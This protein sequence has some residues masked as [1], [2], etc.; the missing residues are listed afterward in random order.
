MDPFI[1]RLEER[2]KLPLPG[3]AAHN[4][5]RAV[6]VGPIRPDFS[7]TQPP[8]PGAV[9]ICLYEKDGEIVFPL[10]K[11]TEY[12][13]A[14]SGQISLPGGKAEPNEEAIGTAL[15]EAEEEI[16]VDPGQIR[17]IGTLTD[18][19]VIP[20]NFLVTPVV[21]AS[22]YTPGFRPDPREVTRILTA[23]L[24]E[25]TR[26]DAIRNKEILAG[27]KFPMMAPHFEVEGEIVWG[28]TAM[29]LNELCHVAREVK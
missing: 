5:M 11:R 25:L 1:S 7:N 14:H 12:L 13:G 28:A 27:G 10:I 21:A 20:S 17:I 26:Q 9:L 19:F 16:G 22:M 8:R 18:F 24:F 4:M 29:I 6:P 3:A 15:R 23:Q 2:L